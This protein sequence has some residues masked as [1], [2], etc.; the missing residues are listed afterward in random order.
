MIT[1]VSLASIGELVRRVR[2]GTNL[3]YVCAVWFSACGW[4]NAGELPQFREHLITKDI[5]YGY[6]LLAVDLTD[7]GKK[8]VVVIDERAAELAWFE[9]PT[10]DRHVLVANVPRQLNADSFDIDGDRVPEIVLAY[11]FE[12]RPE[13]SVGN[14][15]LYE[16]LG[17]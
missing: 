1:S 3:T 6:Q 13:Q 2:W 15:K 5:Q 10:W 12:P 11:N 4:L 17:R 8:D 9:N 16:N 7:D 14:V